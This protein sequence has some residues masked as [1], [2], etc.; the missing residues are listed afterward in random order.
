MTDDNLETC[1]SVSI[2]VSAQHKLS[3]KTAPF[4]LTGIR[5]LS[6]QFDATQSYRYRTYTRV[7]VR[8]PLVGALQELLAASCGRPC[9]EL[10]WQEVCVG[11]RSTRSMKLAGWD[12]KA[13]GAT[14]VVVNCSVKVSDQLLSCN[15]R[16][17]ERQ[18]AAG[19]PDQA[20]RSVNAKSCLSFS[21]IVS[22]HHHHNESCYTVQKEQGHASA[23]RLPC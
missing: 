1:R 19:L 5:T 10:P 17:I 12:L 20:I 8:L 23:C 6:C 16:V 22:Q 2:Q 4:C 9:G 13:Q 15:R 18:L 3:L 21:C 7:T 11:S 14:P